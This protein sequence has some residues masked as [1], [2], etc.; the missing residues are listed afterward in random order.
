MIDNFEFNINGDDVDI[1]LTISGEIN[2]YKYAD[3][4]LPS[5]IKWATHNVTLGGQVSPFDYAT[6][7]EWGE[8]LYPRDR[9][10]YYKSMKKYKKEKKKIG[11]IYYNIQY[12]VARFN[13]GG[14]WRLPTKTEMQ[15]LMYLCKWS[16]TIVGKSKG[17][18]ITGP[19][20]NS[21]FLPAAGYC[22]DDFTGFGFGNNG[23]YW[24]STP[25]HEREEAF[26]LSFGEEGYSIDSFPYNWELSVRPV[27][28]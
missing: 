4:G 2:G 25:N 5:R 6:Y 28:Y 3:L 17:Y 27:S 22:Y 10:K 24:T 8:P 14:T 9:T 7:Y 18:K 12:D 20:G 19:N 15:E 16:W 21:I 13:W 1:E 26:I 11:D 23:R